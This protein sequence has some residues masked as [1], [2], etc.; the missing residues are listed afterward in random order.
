LVRQPCTPHT[1]SA[2]DSAYI[3]SFIDEICLQ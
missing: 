1:S 3:F 2:Q